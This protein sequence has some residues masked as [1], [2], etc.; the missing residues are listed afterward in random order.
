[1]ATKSSDVREKAVEAALALA[2]RRDWNEVSLRDIAKKAKI[3]L[4]KLHEHFD[5]RFDVIAA[6]SRLLD[7]RVLENAS[8]P[9]EDSPARDRLFDVLM[10]R[11]DALNDNRDGAKSIL[12]SLRRDPKQ[13]VIA[14]PNLGR[15]MSWMLEAAGIEAAG[16]SGAL[17]IAG[18]SAAYL[19]ALYAWCDDDSADMAKTM[20]ALDKSLGRA[21]QIGESFGVA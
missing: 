2:A 8:T 11:F 10:E 3:P 18:A 1:M 21:A 16:L 7:R 20:A 15:S 13:A 14:L 4:A 6:W 17:K 12:K 5:D 9:D 19:C